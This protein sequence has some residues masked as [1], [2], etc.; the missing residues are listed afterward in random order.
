VT[1]RKQV[2]ERPRTATVRGPRIG[3]TRTS[4][5]LDDFP[6]VFPQPGTILVSTRAISARVNKNMDG[7]PSRELK[8]AYQTFV[9][10]PVFVNHENLNH[11]KTRGIIR[12]A[13]YVE[14]GKDKFI[15]LCI[16]IDA[17][18]YPRLAAEIE[19][20]RLDGVSM[21]TDVTHT[22]CSYCNNVAR[23]PYEFCSHILYHK[24]STLDRVTDN[25][26]REAVL[27]YEICEGLNFFEI[28]FVFDPADETALVQEVYVP[29]GYYAST[30]K[31]ADQSDPTQMLSDY[32]DQN[33]GPTNSTGNPDMD[34][35]M[36]Q[37]WLQEI[38]SRPDLVAQIQQEM[39]KSSK[40][41]WNFE[42]PVVPRFAYD[43][44]VA[45]SD[46]DTLRDQQECPQCGDDDFDGE[47]CLWCNYI[48]PPEEL[49]DPDL[50]KARDVDLD[51]QIDDRAEQRMDQQ[52]DKSDFTMASRRDR[53]VASPNPFVRRS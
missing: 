38:M 45:P 35:R 41:I 39:G 2:T 12:D 24:G 18:A 37:S 5:L 48:A 36:K 53:A 1:I 10:R 3:S 44:T 51:Q 32:Y 19:A 4:T 25:F 42:S 49:S 21:G 30:M 31:S 28:S 8:A 50:T 20:G 34:N 6:N 23:D 52:R 27:V 29:G 15:K 13:K 46:V 17:R 22:I 11:R 43:E 14:Q 47:R 9:G 16:E 26:Q 7:F 33:I 40:R